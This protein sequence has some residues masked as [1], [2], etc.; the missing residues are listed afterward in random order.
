M[1]SVVHSFPVWLP[2]T[3]TWMYNQVK[4][5]PEDIITHIVCEKTEN[6]DQFNLPNIHCSG[7]RYISII[8]WE[9]LLRFLQ[10]RKYSEYLIEIVRK[11]N[12]SILHS[13][14]GNIG[15]RDLGV[16]KRTGIKHITTFYGRDVNQLPLQYPIW[17]KRYLELF[18]YV[19]G[20]LC[21]GAHM[22]SCIEKLGCPSHKIHV[23]HLGIDICK[24]NYKPRKWE[25]GE[26]LRV[27]I[28][29]TFREKK[30]VPYALM[31]L[32][33][34]KGVINFYITI[35][36]DAGNDA[37]SINEKQKILQTIQDYEI[38]DIVTMMGYLT[39][40]E[41]L[42]QAYSHHIFIS[43]SITA[44]N[45]DTEGGAPV[46]IIELAA[47]G[48]PVVSTSHCD[49]PGIIV[50]GINGWLAA[51]KDV[52]GLVEIIERWVSQRHNWLQYLSA[53]RKH[54]ENEYDAGKQGIHLGEI[55]KSL[56][57]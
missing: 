11:E 50:E 52:D 23:H 4:F 8:Y 18:S 46:S 47:S 6:L 43:P 30:G 57:A 14:F 35:I 24:I 41:L 34:L 37:E 13:H 44:K 7:E 28:A 25:P 42:E 33:K 49:I 32:A 48:M 15:W 1:T 36:G 40:D 26:P 17:R 12:V 54:V 19:D 31:A 56:L 27:L 39:H 45:G 38:S 3:Q 2:Q 51:E 5:L 20:I 55:Y 10:I 9:K 53:G 29:S 22:A 21:E 16:I